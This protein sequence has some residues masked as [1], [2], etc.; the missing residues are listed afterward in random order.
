MTDTDTGT[1]IR[2]LLEKR[3]AVSARRSVLA[4]VSGI[5]G[6]GKGYIT[7]QL[8]AGLASHGMKVA[9]INIDGWLNLPARRFS[10]TEP[11]KHFY[12]HAIRF[13]EM[14]DQ[15]VLPLKAHR[16]H[17]LVA[18]FAEETA[19]AY[20]PHGY[21]F[22][23]VDIIL[24]EGI[25]LLKRAHRAHFDMAL[26]VDC[27]FETALERALR[28]G[29]EGLPPDETIRAY[30]TIYFPAQRIHFVRDDPRRA[31]DLIVANDPRLTAAGP[32]SGGRPPSVGGDG[33]AP[34][35]GAA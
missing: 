8:A 9:S 3:R 23:D 16:T 13:R 29:Q 15:L 4:A 11:A 19:T 22:D 25:F 14:F 7:G 17:R 1:A 24:L 20:R 28:R 34:A 30:E 6:S 33:N 10:A 18:D 2:T 12:E 5:D 35:P 26:W 27:S 31:A 32:S 21:Q